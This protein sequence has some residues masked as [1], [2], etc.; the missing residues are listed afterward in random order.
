M[1]Q[2]KIQT[3]LKV[4][5]FALGWIMTLQRAPGRRIKLYFSVGLIGSVSMS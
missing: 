3:N 2:F 5:F 4:S 1:C